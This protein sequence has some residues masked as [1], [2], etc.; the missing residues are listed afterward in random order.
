MTPFPVALPGAQAS[1]LMWAGPAEVELAAL[2]QL[3][4]IS[5]PRP[6]ARTRSSRSSPA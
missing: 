2:E 3:R 4:T 1:T 5:R 6:A